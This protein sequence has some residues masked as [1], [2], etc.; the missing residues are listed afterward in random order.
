MGKVLASQKV[1]KPRGEVHIFEERCK[2]CEF[3]I[4]FCP[5]DVLER[6]DKINEKGYH[7]PKLVED[8]PEKVCLACEFC[9]RIC[10]EFAIWVEE[11]KKKPH[12]IEK[13]KQKMKTV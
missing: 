6:S 2:E 3:C 9:E 7:P 13:P 12:K 10:P 11:K 5:G 8:P 1:E 4:E